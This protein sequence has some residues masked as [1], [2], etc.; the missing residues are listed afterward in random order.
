MS[1]TRSI[2]G[3]RQ[4]RAGEAP[5]VSGRNNSSLSSQQFLSQ[6]QQQQPSPASNTSAKFQSLNSQSYPP[7]RSTIQN[8]NQNSIPQNTNTNANAAIKQGPIRIGDG[9]GKLSVSDA[10]ALVTLRLGKIET[11][12]NK[13]LEQGIPS[14]ENSYNHEHN[15]NSQSQD[16]ESILNRLAALEQSSQSHNLLLNQRNTNTNTQNT[17]NTQI[18]T[19]ENKLAHHI[20]NKIEDVNKDLSEVK[21]TLLK[22]QTFAM[23]TNQKLVNAIFQENENEI[24]MIRM[25]NELENSEEEQELHDESSVKE[26]ELELESESENAN[27]IEGSENITVNL[28]EIIKNELKLSE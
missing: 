25:M 7:Q 12:I 20:D 15:D 21:E 2:A 17:Q 18:I 9:P 16:L 6:Q 24:M 5:P 8:Q 1:S 19:L 23:E 11:Q 10:F 13:W 4:R 14:H 3:A 26:L 28:K 27:P 22:I